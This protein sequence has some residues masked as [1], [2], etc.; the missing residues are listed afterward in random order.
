M[1][2][3]LKE[4]FGKV[5]FEKKVR[6]LQLKHETLPS[7]QTCANLDTQFHRLNA[8]CDIHPDLPFGHIRPTSL[9][10]YPPGNLPTPLHSRI[11]AMIRFMG[12]TA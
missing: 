7:M 4:L 6:I 2:V 11:N 8:I 9:V 1:L 12:V 5:N 10:N 3:F